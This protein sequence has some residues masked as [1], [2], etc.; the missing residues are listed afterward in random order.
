VFLVENT[1]ER[2]NRPYFFFRSVDE[3]RARFSWAALKPIG[4][5]EDLGERI[6]VLAGRVR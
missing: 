3:Y 5:Y 1:A 6:S 4:D 2:P